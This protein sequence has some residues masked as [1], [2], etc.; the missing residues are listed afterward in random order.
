MAEFDQ[1]VDNLDVGALRE[2]QARGMH[3]F[4]APQVAAG[5]TVVIGA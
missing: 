4:R 1:A 2:L 5:K 3:V